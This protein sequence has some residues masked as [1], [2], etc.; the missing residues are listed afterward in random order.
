MSQMQM[1]VFS[2]QIFVFTPKGDIITLPKGSTP[3]DFAYSI[4]SDLGNSL[5]IAKVN[6]Q[7]VPLDYA[8]HNGESI[9]IVT[10][11][12][13]KPNPIW[14]SY[15]K[16]QKARDHIRQYINREE[17][18]YFIEKGRQI[19]NAYLEKNYGKSLDHELSLLKYIDGRTLNTQEKEDVLVQLGNL[20]RKP[21]SILRAL[22]DITIRNLF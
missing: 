14:L 9:Q 5:T 7:V 13:R 16:T 10:D 19:L 1:N 12:N 22:N 6:G 21:S 4:H 2:D 3:V 18:S 17:R 20:S 11:K 15:V 8:L